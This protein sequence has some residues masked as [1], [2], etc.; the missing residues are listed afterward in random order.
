ML[1]RA[2]GE[3][4]NAV[5]GLVDIARWTPEGATLTSPIGVRRP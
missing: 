4:R 1:V 5:A 3:Q 2:I